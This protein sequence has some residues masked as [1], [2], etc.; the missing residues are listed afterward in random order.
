MAAS[1]GQFAKVGQVKYIARL[2]SSRHRS[3]I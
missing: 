3:S 2:V 1:L